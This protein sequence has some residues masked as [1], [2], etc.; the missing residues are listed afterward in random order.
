MKMDSQNEN[1]EKDFDFLKLQYQILANKQLQHDAMIW[2]MPSILF[3]CLALLWGIAVDK[4]VKEVIHL[5]ASVLAVIISFVALQSLMRIRL[6]EES[7]SQQLNSIER[8]FSQHKA[9]MI[10]HN[11]LEERTLLNDKEKFQW[12]IFLLSHEKPFFI[13]LPSVLL[14]KIAFGLSLAASLLLFGF[15]S[16]DQFIKLWLKH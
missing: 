12:K 10:I 11:V 8:F 2:N 1:N 14:W 9:A 7:D 4:D 5:G 16:Y 3:V 13:K 15:I 6:M